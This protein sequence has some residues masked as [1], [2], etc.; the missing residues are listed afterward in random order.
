MKKIY[1][2]ILICICILSAKAQTI[3]VNKG[4]SI[5]FQE[6]KFLTLDT[7]TIRVKYK[8]YII[9]DTSNINSRKENL[10]L[11]QIGKRMSKYTDYNALTGDSLI[12]VYT[13]ESMDINTMMGKVRNYMKGN[14]P[15]TIFK[16]YPDRKMSTTSFFAANSYKYEEPLISADWQ[17]TAGNKTICGYSCKKAT[18][19]FFGRKYIAWYTTQIPTNNGP[20]KFSGLP[21]LILQVEDEKKQVAFECITIEKPRWTDNITI[22]DKSYIKT[23][24]KTFLKTYKQYRENPAIILRSSGLIQN[25]LPARALQK[26]PYNPIE[27]SE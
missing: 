4:E 9:N 17:L 18:A 27:L 21:G 7:A 8:Q 6:E 12:T 22:P 10:M 26:R 23:D 16:N 2:L 13:K 19:I 5:D 15:E 11:L 25:D 20:W 14:F 1:I 24:K 3:T